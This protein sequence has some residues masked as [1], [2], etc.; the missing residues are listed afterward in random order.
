MFFLSI[1]EAGEKAGGRQRT[2]ATHV[3]AAVRA[4]NRVVC[5]GETMRATLNTRAEGTPEWLRSFAPDEWYERCEHRV[6]DYRLCH[7]C[8]PSAGGNVACDLSSGT[9]AKIHRRTACI[10]PLRNALYQF[11]W[12]S[13]MQEPWAKAYYQRKRAEGKSHSMALRALT[14][15]WIR[16]IYTIW[17]IH[18]VYEAATFEAAQQKHGHQAA[19]PG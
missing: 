4:I 17:Y 15:V 16:I 2:D 7:P 5:V 1:T 13:T 3:L 12:Q 19:Q 18:A 10:K 8:K 14:N 6:E 11:A 9:Y